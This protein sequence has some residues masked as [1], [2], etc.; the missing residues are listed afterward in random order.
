M[1]LTSYS[2]VDLLTSTSQNF[3]S[4]VPERFLHNQNIFIVFSQ[5]TAL[6]RS[7]KILT[8]KDIDNLFPRNR[9]NTAVVQS[10][11]SGGT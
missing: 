4:F 9:E 2:S 1:S 11:D 10:L 5:C 6:S 3:N 7:N 8:V